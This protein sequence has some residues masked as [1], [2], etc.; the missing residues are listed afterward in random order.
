MGVSEKRELGCFLRLFNRAMLLLTALACLFMLVP[1]QSNSIEY[2]ESAFGILGSHTKNIEGFL[3]PEGMTEEQF[4]EWVD[5]H[6]TVLCA[7]WTRRAC[8]LTWGAIEPVL[9]GGYNWNAVGCEADDYSRAVY[10]PPNQIELLAG[11]IP[12]D[13]GDG[14]SPMSYPNEFA[15]F[16][17]AAA[18]RY[19]GD[20]IDDA[21]S[22]IKINY[23]Q[24]SNELFDWFDQ[25]YSVEDYAE[26]ARITLEALRKAN[27]KAR[28]V[29]I[30]Q[31]GEGVSL[32]TRLKNIIT[33]CRDKD[34]DFHAADL[35]LWGKAGDWQSKS[36]I[37]L[38]QFLDASGLTEVEIWSVE[39]GTYVGCPGDSGTLPSQTETEQARFLIKRYAW[40]RTNGFRRI[41]WNNLIDFY[42]FNNSETSWFNGMGL[43][44]DGQLICDPSTRGQQRLSYWAYQLLAQ[45]TDTLVAEQVGQMSITTGDIYGYE[46]KSLSS[47]LPLYVVWHEA[48]GSQISLPETD[49]KVTVLSLITDSSG[50]ATQQTLEAASGPIT[51]T[52]GPDPLLVVVTESSTATRPVA[53]AG[54]DQSVK[55]GATVTLD[56]SNS[57][58]P[59]DGIAAYQWN[60]ISGTV[61]TLSDPASAQTTFLAP[62]VG[63]EGGTMSF[64]LTVTDF[65][66]YSTTDTC[67]V[68]VTW[69]NQ[70]PVANAGPDQSVSDGASVI[71]DAS[72]SSDPDDGIAAY[73]WV[74]SSG[75]F[76]RIRNRSS[77]QAGFSPPAV[78]VEGE[79]L[80]FELT[81]ADTNGL[82]SMDVCIV[83]VTRVNQA[84]TAHAGQDQTVEEGQTVTLDGSGSS[85]D[86]GDIL[87]Y[88]WGQV[89]GK[90]V[91]LSD[92]T[93]SRPTFFPT[94]LESGAETLIFE[95][96]VT[97]TDGLQSRDQISVTVTDN[98]ISAFPEDVIPFATATGEILGIKEVNGHIV[99][100]DSVHP[101]QIIEKQNRPENIIYGLLSI[102]IK[103]DSPGNAARMEIY[104][105][106]SASDQFF[107]YKYNSSYGWSV[108]DSQ[109]V[110]N[111]DRTRI[112]LY[113][114]DGGAGDDDGVADGIILD[115]SGLAEPP[116]AS[117]Q[118]SSSGGGCFIGVL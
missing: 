4:H 32:D 15:A 54:P 99:Y 48:G 82:Q 66:G 118:D 5:G 59:D 29:L 10:E 62:D 75:S 34:V 111:A 33:A 83:N 47:G 97:D 114:V 22:N 106:N 19:D 51:L 35:H 113:F 12:T 109:T 18:E 96:T 7:H 98:G 24:L 103:V 39:N 11:I 9:G 3:A 21:D 2:A 6:M 101:N 52:V 116:A 43:I 55:E 49:L 63:P 57:S 91:T 64:R 108:Y 41:F 44:G 61:V 27:P 69:V 86:D 40:G 17:K 88:L 16:V 31:A 68:N 67:I 105:P 85:D 26:A 53:N 13:S 90:A 1:T 110:F 73:Q 117:Q 77:V 74:Q 112:A 56:A 80:V 23:F 72:G 94:A 87:T 102:Q 42:Q 30:A 25:G 115:P 76:V 93:A 107:W 78:G 50:N 70:A 58:D 89:S 36:V 28:L 45:Y 20:G 92:P 71:L 8:L 95:L 84:P 81:V 60:Q 46:Y 65:S 14:R 104:L 38:R 79:S 37:E 100:L